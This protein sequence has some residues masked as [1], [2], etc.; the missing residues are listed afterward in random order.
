MS[1]YYPRRV[2][3]I[4]DL[5]QR[6]ARKGIIVDDEEED[7][8]LEHIAE[9]VPRHESDVSG[10]VSDHEQEKAAWQGREEEEGAR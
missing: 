10:R 7:D 2:A 4:K 5:Q 6:M 1:A 3:T 8:R 9:Y